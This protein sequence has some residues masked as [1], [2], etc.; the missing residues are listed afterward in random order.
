MPPSMDSVLQSPGPIESF[1]GL[2]FRSVAARIDLEFSHLVFKALH[3]LMVVLLFAPSPLEP[4]PQPLLQTPH[5]SLLYSPLLTFLSVLLK[6][7]SRVYLLLTPGSFPLFY[8]D[9]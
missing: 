2:M 1:F 4:E 6:M 9:F 3:V 7:Q 5:V 8:F